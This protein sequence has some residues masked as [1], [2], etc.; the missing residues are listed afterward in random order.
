MKKRAVVRSSNGVDHNNVSMDR[1]PLL[2][3]YKEVP[4][5]I[6]SIPIDQTIKYLERY[7]CLLIKKRGSQEKGE[8]EFDGKCGKFLNWLQEVRSSHEEVK[9]VSIVG[10]H[11]KRRMYFVAVRVKGIV[12]MFQVR[13]RCVDETLTARASEPHFTPLPWTP[14][15]VPEYRSFNRS[16][17]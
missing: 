2:K 8:D 13:Q 5:R 16:Y 7:R 14:E 17:A 15:R 6:W 10:V 12:K 9:D 3:G 1:V 4:E 11:L